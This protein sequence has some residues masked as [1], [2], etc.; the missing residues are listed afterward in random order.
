MRVVGIFVA[1]VPVV[2]ASEVVAVLVGVDVVIQARRLHQRV[3]VGVT[4]VGITVWADGTGRDG[5]ERGETRGLEG[6]SGSDW[7]CVG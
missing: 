4:V 3:G 1:V 7:F 2:A 5:A 6:R